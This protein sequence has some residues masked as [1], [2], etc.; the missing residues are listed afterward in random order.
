MEQNLKNAC[1]EKVVTAP[2]HIMS[3]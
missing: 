2:L 1:T 3:F